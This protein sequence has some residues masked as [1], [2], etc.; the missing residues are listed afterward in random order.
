MKARWSLLAFA[1]LASI[2]ALA[3]TVTVSPAS[4]SFG[5][6]VEGTTSSVQKVTLKNGQ[7]SAITITSITANLSDYA[8]T[9]NCPVS[10]ATL[11]A[12]TSCTVS[13]TF[14]PSALGTRSGALTVADSGGSSPQLVTLNG[15]GTPPSLVSIAVTPA[16]ASVA[17]GHTEQFT[18]TGSYSNGTKQNL[19]SSATWSSSGTAIATVNGGGLATSL[20]PGTTTIT[21]TSGTVTGSAALAVTLPVLVSLSVNPGSASIAKGASQQFAAVGTYSDGSTQDLTGGVSWTSSSTVASIGSGGLASGQGVGIAIITATSGSISGSGTLNV[22]QAVLVS[23]AVTP[24]NASLAMGTTLPLVATGTYSDGST[25]VVT[26]TA[27]WAMADASI[28]TVNNQG[29]ASSVVLGS[30]TVTATLGTIS[31]STGVTVNPAVLV[32]IAV[33]PAV[34]VIP[35]GTTE[36]F[37]ATGTYTDGSTQNITSTVEWSSD[38]QGVSTISTGGPA[39]GVASGAGVGSANITA[40]EGGVSGSTTL[41][42]TAAALVSM[43]VTPGTPT[44]A[45][46]TTEQFTATGTYTDGSTQ[47]LTSTA[48]WSSDTPATATINSAGMGQSVGTGTATVSATSGAVS[49]VTELTVTAAALVSI[50][51]NPPT[52][53]IAMGTTEQFTATGTFTDGTTQ[54]LTQSGNWSSTV[55]TVATISDTAGTMGQVSTTGV[56]TTTIGISSGT[57]SGTATLVVN[58]AALVSIV[59]NPLTATIGL[60]TTQQFTAMGT[61][62]DGSTQDLT[63]VVTWSSSSATVAIMGNAIGSYGLATSAGQGT[64]NITASLNAITGSGTI[65]VAGP[66]LVSIAITP[67]GVAI[68]LGTGQQFDAVGT[69]TDGSTQDLTQSATW[70]ASVA[71]VATLGSAGYATSV[72][73]GTTTITATSGAV[74]E[75]VVLVVNSAMPISLIV[76]PA[77]SSI[78]VGAQQQ[79]GGT[80]NYSDGSSVNVTSTVTWNS[81]NPGVATVNSSGLAVGVTGGSSAITATWG[82]NIFTASGSLTVSAPMPNI[83]YVSPAGSDSNPCVNSSAPCLTIAHAES[84]SAAGDTINI[85]AGTYR[86][87]PGGSSNA[88]YISA[89]SNQTFVG[90]TCTP[91]SG[92]CQAVISGGI[93]IGGLALG[94]DA[95]G[96]WYVTGQTQHGT[97][98]TA[99]SCD[100]GWGACTY[101]ED[102]FFNGVPL[103]HVVASSEPTLT[104]TQW[105]FDYTNHIIYFHQNPERNTVETSVLET[106][107][108]PNRANN[109][110]ISGL[111]FEEFASPVQSGAIDPG[112]GT[113]PT[114]NSGINWTIENSYV[115]LNHGFGIRGAFGMQVLNNVLTNNGDVGLGGGLLT[116]PDITPSGLIIQGNTITYNN[117]AHIFPGFGAGGIKFGNTAYA[118]V[119]GNTVSNNLGDGIHFDGDSLFPLIDGNTVINNSDPAAAGGTSGI[120]FEIGFGGAM[121]RNNVIQYNGTGATSGPNVQLLS[122]TSVG[123]QAYCNVV[124]TG[125]SPHEGALEVTAADRGYNTEQP[126]LGTYMVSTG[127]YFHHNTAIWDS[128]STAPAG[129]FQ[130]DETNQPNF[131]SVNTP[132]NFN[133]YHA[134]STGLPVFA[135]DNVGG[136]NKEQ[137]FTAYQSQGADVNSTM[138]T[139]YTSGFPTVSITSPVDQSFVTSPVTVAA[140]ASDISGINNVELYVDWDLAATATSSPYNFT[141]SG[142]T[143][144]AHTVAAVAYSNAGIR[145]CYAVTLNN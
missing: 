40:S 12:S 141:V 16:A 64:A 128:G 114:S 61:Y 49:G 133:Q 11:A 2:P 142:L 54:D 82:A 99:A 5:N 33:T 65:S 144:G 52:A 19:T 42:V 75:S 32:S 89:K 109:L 118:T 66:T 129:Y 134:S 46:G 44:I 45:L 117:Y 104:A 57:V 50:A 105:W 58:P 101:P 96:N 83:W 7:S 76:T 126:Y 127:N 100:T 113:T 9:N 88:G 138:D 86:L 3:Q 69:Y 17:A 41:T 97:V 21:A 108:S 22:G 121:V 140:T 62:T 137:N 95:S 25:L 92:P 78:L 10:P 18:A 103:L 60:G 71:G 79:F 48:T 67:N 130:N 81:L 122:A 55:A 145:N 56:G 51:I 20:T 34:P 85:A 123:M 115:T 102:L 29:V 47:N 116:G 4:L 53:T 14:K 68:P 125:T 112:Y 24:A 124:E 13:I 37:T 43:V 84:L 72:T 87:S 23:L 119:R 143:P 27:S 63:T 136:D 110:T 98:D 111:T 39:P 35:L 90:P 6:Q 31:G 93:S 77:S 91:A 107:F 1:A 26:N 28:A 15:T 70:A 59:I 36:V 8:A 131:F 73:P 106:A 80:L 139:V 74:T 135:Y 30:T 132:P 120:V 38:T 94:P